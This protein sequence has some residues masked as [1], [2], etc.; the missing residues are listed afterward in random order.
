MGLHQTKQL[1]HSKRNSHKTQET[2]W[3]KIFATYS[4]DKGLI[5]VI[6]GKLKKLNLQR[7]K[8]SMKKWARELN[9]KSSKQEV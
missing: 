1:L 9:K 5:G 6:Y 7:I 2:K 8:T 3:E 4:S